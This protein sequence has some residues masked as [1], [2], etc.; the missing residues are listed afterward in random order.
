MPIV[1]YSHP[2]EKLYYKDS[3]F[4]SRYI[5]KRTTRTQDYKE[6]HDTG[7]FVK[8]IWEQKQQNKMIGIKTSWLNG[9]DIDNVED[10]IKQSSFLKFLKKLNFINEVQSHYL[11]HKK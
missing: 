4:I 8:K 10:G 7:F 6:S 2:I 11:F 3:K 5:K 1:K 9:I